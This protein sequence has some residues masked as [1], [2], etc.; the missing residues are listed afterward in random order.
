[1]SK[2]IENPSE[3]LDL[4]SGFRISRIILTAYELEIFSD[5]KEAGL[6]SIELAI[7]KKLDPR[8]TDR[9]MNALVSLGL[10]QKSGNQFTNTLF[11]SK[12]LVK[13]QSGYLAGLSHQAH[14]WRTWSTLTE[15]I[16]AGT[17]VAV[18]KPIGERDENWLDSFIAAMHS[19]GVPQSKEV[20][21]LLDF[22]NIHSIL[23][24]GGGS[25]AFTFE[26]IR[27]CNHATAVV[28]DLPAVVPITQKYIQ[29]TGLKNIITTL[30]GD[31]LT[32]KFG[33]GYDLVFVSAVIHIN[34]PEENELL[35]NKCFDA[36]NPHG[37]LVIL[38]HFMNDD[39]TEPKAGAIFALNMIVGTLHGDT[40]TDNEVRNWMSNSGLKDIKRKDSKQ[41]TSLLIGRK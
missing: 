22:S 5:L 36:L 12:Y 31:Y 14:L 33:S 34:S 27:R 2:E 32:D 23:D 37:Q 8:A 3:L 20:A 21:D 4:V 35:I 7:K 16:K 38:D 15:A 29:Q 11:S 25:G 24:V 26:F 9:F 19:R 6:S 39:R 1:M 10:L 41:G 17:S 30:P 13:G 18:E 28:F 40:Y